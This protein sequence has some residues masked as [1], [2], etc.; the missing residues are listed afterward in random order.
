MN[1]SFAPLR[2][3][4]INPRMTDPLYDE[5]LEIQM[6]LEESGPKSHLPSAISHADGCNSMLKRLAYL[7]RQRAALLARIQ[8]GEVDAASE[9]VAEMETTLTVRLATA[10]QHLATFQSQMQSQN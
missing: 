8:A 9:T 7:E 4:V 1:K 2:L 5:Q 3:C 10:R 6:Q